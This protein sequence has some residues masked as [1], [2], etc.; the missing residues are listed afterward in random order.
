MFSKYSAAPAQRPVTR[1][2]LIAALLLGGLTGLRA[3]PAAV[4]LPSP[5]AFPESLSSTRDGTLFIGSF[6]EGGILRAKPGAAVAESWIK[7]GANGSRSTFGVLADEESNTLWVCSNDVSGWGVPGPGN[8]KGS[9]LIGFDL[10]TG[11]G[12]SNTPLP[13]APTLCN[14]IAIG[15]DGAAYVTDSLQPHILRLA[16]GASSFEVWSE[17]PRFTP[18]KG[19][20][21]LDGIAFGEDGAVYVDTFTEAKLFRVAVTGGKAGAVTP[22]EPSRKLALTD[23]LRAFGPGKF[24]LIEGSGSLDLMTV[25]GTRATITTIKDGFA[26]PVSVTQVGSTGWVAEGQLP[27]LLDPQLKDQQPKPFQLHAVPLP[28]E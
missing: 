21:G 20:A 1:M 24:L 15:P 2:G 7:P 23:A 12:K 5:R 4:S 10:K 14:D 11:E 9:A 25:E 3:E 16:P 28:A 26:G 22:L 17:D 18:P 6:S 8:S 13:G 27:Y 19:G